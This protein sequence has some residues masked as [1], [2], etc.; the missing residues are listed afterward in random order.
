MEWDSQKKKAKEM[1]SK[2]KKKSSM[3]LNQVI[4]LKG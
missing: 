4:H 1:F 3:T 2:E